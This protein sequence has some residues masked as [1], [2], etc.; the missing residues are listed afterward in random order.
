MALVTKLLV[1]PICTGVIG[2]FF[3]VA[4][5][6]SDSYISRA[7]DC[8]ASL[9]DYTY[10]LSYVGTIAGSLNNADARNEQIGTY[11]IEANEKFSAPSSRIANKCDTEYFDE[12]NLAQWQDNNHEIS[13]RCFANRSCTGSEALSLAATAQNLTNNLLNDVHAVTKWG[14]ARR[15]AYMFRHLY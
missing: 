8:Y 7:D 14:T 2:L 10:G 9:L 6:Q 15:V 3:G 5:D 13:S 12:Q 4:L 1:L 11:N